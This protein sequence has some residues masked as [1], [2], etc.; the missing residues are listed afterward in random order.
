MYVWRRRRA[1]RRVT[2]AGAQK[3][4][5]DDAPRDAE[6]PADLVVGVSLHVAQDEDLRRPGAEPGDGR[7]QAVSQFGLGAHFVG[8][9]LAGVARTGHRLQRRAAAA[10]AQ[11]VQRQVHGGPVEVRTRVRTRVGAGLPFHEPEKQAV[12]HVLGVAHVPGDPERGAED[13]GMMV[14]VEP[15]DVGRQSRGGEGGRG[16]VHVRHSFRCLLGE[17]RLSGGF[18]NRVGD[19]F[20]LHRSVPFLEVRK[21]RADC[22]G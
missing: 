18:I 16:C 6:H 9:R 14:P 2:A 17:R 4:D 13:H 21:D 15:V 19:I 10:L 20:H 12:Q 11:E 1:R 8:P 5:G 3:G 7:A 22:S